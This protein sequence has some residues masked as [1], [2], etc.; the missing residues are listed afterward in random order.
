MFSLV[1]ATASLQDGVSV[2]ELLRGITPFALLVLGWMQKRGA[3]DRAEI[4]AEQKRDNERITALEVH[5]AE[6]RTHVGIDGNGLTK[7]LS[8]LIDEVRGLRTDLGGALVEMA[9]H[10]GAQARRSS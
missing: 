7:Q 4:K 5:N 1:Q 9:E 6:L 8:D 2:S 10:R 3:D